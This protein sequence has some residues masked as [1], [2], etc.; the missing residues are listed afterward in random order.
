MFVNTV[1]FSPVQKY[2]ITK[3]DPR[4]LEYADWWKEERRRCIEGYDV[5]G[6]HITG[7][8]YWYLN[9]WKIRGLADNKGS[10]RKSLIHPQFLDLDYW[11]FTEIDKAKKLGKNFLALKA[12]QKGFSE[13]A[14]SLMGR[15]FSLF[16]QSQTIITAG[17]DKY[18]KFTTSMCVR[19]LN[20][21]EGTEF[22]KRRNPDTADHMVARYKTIVDG[23]VVWR[24]YNSQI[25]N[26]TSKNNVQALVGKSP[27]FV[28][29][30]EA[31]RFKGIKDVYRYILPAIRSQGQK[32]GFILL[33]GT[34]GEMDQ[35]A[36]ELADMF[37]SPEAF[38]LMEYD[39]IWDEAVDTNNITGDL[40]KVAYFVP[41]YH[42]ELIDDEGNSLIEESKKVF[43]GFRETARK[44]NDTSGY[45]NELTQRPF[46]PSEALLI[47]GGNIFNQVL[48]NSRLAEIRRSKELSSIPQYGDLRWKKDAAGHING[49]E[50]H[51]QKEGP[52]IIIEHPEQ[53]PYNQV[54]RNLYVGGTDSYD[55]DE[56]GGKYGSFGS[57]Q[58]YKKF[59][60]ADHT[61]DLFV[62]RLTQRPKTAFEFYENSAKL[63]YYYGMCKNLIEYS[64]LRIFDW[65]KA[66]GWEGM[67][68]ERPK[69]AYASTKN[70]TAKNPYGIHAATKDE[71]L[72]MGRD[73]VETFSENMFD[74]GQI[75]A[76]TKFQNNPDYNCDITISTCLCVLHAQDDK[77]IKAT[78]SRRETI[79]YGGWKLQNG[80][81][82]YGAA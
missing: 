62:A 6:L 20:A 48:L 44:S 46:T 72:T 7:E 69:V 10:N 65:Y 60:N 31:G 78:E 79:D 70:S 17:E 27:D 11:F 50:W 12:R 52:F 24:G 19:G 5:G 68:K 63:C 37:Y 18:S 77:K 23:T 61:H 14:A 3:A 4:T 80:R 38:N 36:Q 57:C 43:E 56:T 59:L 13:K 67:L 32:T 2:G 55:F 25:F 30:E 16:P 8:H 51:A 29:F 9:Y 75:E 35:G 42:Y 15:E 73:Y 71:W 1:E 45:Y 54:W 39:N 81:I 22:F 66:N 58:I 76:L 40:K 28:Y 47:T 49:I 82:A 53:D 33:A 74:V 64:N 26:I 34:G 21:L 41:A